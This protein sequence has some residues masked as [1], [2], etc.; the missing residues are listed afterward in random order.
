MA[1]GVT[2]SLTIW[3]AALAS[4]IL[5]S[6]VAA[7][8]YLAALAAANTAVASACAILAEASIPAPLNRNSLKFE[9]SDF[10]G[11]EN[12]NVKKTT[13]AGQTNTPSNSANALIILIVFSIL[14]A[15]SKMA[16]GC[17]VT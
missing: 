3:A 9:K 17:N 13:I 16:N 11:P 12:R 6:E 8:S 1:V 14:C 15:V 2:Y 4:L 10:Y 7:D 5:I